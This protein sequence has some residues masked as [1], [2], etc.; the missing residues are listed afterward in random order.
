MK[1]WGMFVIN[2]DFKRQIAIELPHVV[3]DINTHIEGADIFR[4]TASRFLV[5]AGT[6]RC[7]NSELSPCDGSFTGCGG[8]RYPVSDMAHFTASPFQVTHETIFENL[9]QV[10]AFSIHGHSRGDC[11]DIFLS[12]GR[13]EGSSSLLFNIKAGLLAAGGVSVGIAGDGI[14]LCPLVGSTN[15]QGRFSNGSSQPC[16]QAASSANG[17]FIHVEQ[18]RRVRE[19]FS[20][21]S[22]LIDAINAK[23]SI[24]TDVGRVEPD[25]GGPGLVEMFPNPFRMSTTIG[26]EILSE[27]LQVSVRVFNLQG[28]LICVLERNVT[29]APGQYHMIW[30]GRDEAGRPLSNG[31]YFVELSAGKTVSTSKVLLLH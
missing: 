27:G 22:K 11:E 7:A 24:L 13:S 3:Y 2:P 17:W 8:Q 1:G 31:V 26:Y 30:N 28:R 14:S 5:M 21:Y 12:N 16:T 19:T 15:V 18:S 10:Y 29:K 4:R 20:L 25:Q 9:E 6:H 23:I